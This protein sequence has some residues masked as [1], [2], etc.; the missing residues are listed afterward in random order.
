M[1]SSE[2]RSGWC[3]GRV[4]GE[5]MSLV[6]RCTTIVQSLLRRRRMEDEMDAEMRLHIEAV[7]DDRVHSG[8]SGAEAERFAHVE[9]GSIE[10]AKE[11]CREARGVRVFDEL[12]QDLRYSGRNLRKSPGFAAI[13]VLSL[14]VGIG[15]NAAI[16]TVLKALILNPLPFRQPDRL[17]LLW[18]E[19]SKRGI[20]EEGTGFLTVQDWK[21]RSHSFEDLA[22]CSRGNPVFLS[23]VD[24]P[25]RIASEIVSSNFF[26]LLGTAPA[27]GRTFTTDEE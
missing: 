27:L 21:Q 24:P 20:H 25:E 10:A 26:P 12:A 2:F 8:M 6:S 7:I 23:G 17:M 22:I 13:A 5:A 1:E 14:G 16:F 11:Q 4:T 15:A 3:D 19:D 18:T 9:F